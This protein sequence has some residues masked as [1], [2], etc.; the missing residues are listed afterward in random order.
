MT[1][2]SPRLSRAT[3]ATAGLLVAAVLS[4]SCSYGP[5]RE[6]P[7]AIPPGIPPAAG[8]PV[9]TID[10][11]APGRTSDQLRPWAEGIN[12][13]MDIPVAALAAYGNAAE[14]MRQT[15]PE[16]NLA[17]TT[18]AGIGHVET[19]HG[20]YRG[21]SL[22]DDGYA[23]PPIIG[24]KLDGSPGFAE[25]PDTDGGE[26]DGDTEHDRA[27]GP[28]QFIPESWRKYGR[29]ANGDGRADPNQIDDAAIGAARLLCAT[30]GDLSVAENWQRAIL[31]YNAS[32]E[33]V[34]SVRDAAA[35]YSVGTTAP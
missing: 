7:P 33:Y 19:R 5:T 12:Q 1:T 18:L 4:S 21:A 11:H 16:C 13:P 14:T 9:P 3:A 28:M 10:I 27:V 20:R 26:W 8:A 15:Q 24:I 35:A 29:D 22:N 17:W 25:I 2:R 6:A 23:L 31:A 34:M 32:Q 30:G